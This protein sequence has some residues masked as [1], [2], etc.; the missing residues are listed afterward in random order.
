MNYLLRMRY[1]RTAQEFAKR[2]NIRDLFHI[3]PF[4]EAQGIVEALRSNNLNPAK[5]WCRE[6]APGSKLA[7]HLEFQEYIEHVRADRKIDAISF[8]QKF[9]KEQFWNDYKK[10][11]LQMFG[12]VVFGCNTEVPRYKKLFDAERLEFLVKLFNEEFNKF[13]KFTQDASSLCLLLIAGIIALKASL[14]YIPKDRRKD[15]KTEDPLQQKY[16]DTMALPLVCSKLMKPRLRCY[17]TN[18]QMNE[19]NPPFM[20]PNG[21]AYSQEAILLM[22][23]GEDITCSRTGCVYKMSDVK[24]LKLEGQFGYSLQLKKEQFFSRRFTN[25]ALVL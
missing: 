5:K 12:A 4:R 21:R 2:R 20:L 22:Q 11:V 25:S 13:H 10:E 17:V 18:K 19:K 16:F 9:V 14:F 7:Y 23:N 6:N 8:A 3:E 1:L 24:Q 15:W